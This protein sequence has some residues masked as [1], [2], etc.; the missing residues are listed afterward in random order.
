M[1]SGA[2]NFF[3]DITTEREHFYFPL[4]AIKK[5]LSRRRQIRF[6]LKRDTNETKN[7]VDISYVD[8]FVKKNKWTHE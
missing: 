2:S 3:R 4:T 6:N 1:K 7:T 5:E 8:L